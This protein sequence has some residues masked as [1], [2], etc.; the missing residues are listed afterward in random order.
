MSTKSVITK[1]EKAKSASYELGIT[2]TAKKN[3]ALKLLADNLKKYSA[4]IINENK[5]DLSISKNLGDAFLDRLELNNKRIEDLINQINK[6]V[7]LPDPIGEIIDKNIRSDG[8]KISRV[9]VALGVIGVIY[10]SRPN[11]TIDIASLCLKT[12]NSVILR[13]GKESFHTNLFLSKL[14]RSSLSSVGINKESVQFIEN[15]ER[16]TIN[17]LLKM[18]KH[19]DLMIPRGGEQLINLV[20]KESTM[21]SIVGGIGV[22]H[23]YIDKSAD[24]KQSIEIAINSKTQRPSVCNAL[25]TILVHKKIAPEFTPSIISALNT[26]NVE[27]KC[28]PS[29]FSLIDKNFKDNMNINEATEND[30]GTE[31]LSLKISIKTVES[32]Q[33]AI[34]HIKKY[35][36]GHT[37]AITA[38][39]EVARNIFLKEIDASAVMSNASTRFNDGGEFGLGAEIAISTNKFHARGP[40]GLDSLTSYKWI[41]EGSG[42]IRE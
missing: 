29:T 28:D 3:K 10:E 18:D 23:L 6:I 36:S 24:L 34:E 26:K 5:K 13:G 20:S 37:E 12:G 41:V 30:W 38:K 4:D 31:F 22:T 7:K 33:E 2:S 42:H 14:I 11:V 27:I 40:M 32:L 1:A 15:T 39:D 16:S 17:D 9:K 35:G 8:L 19:I 21:P 25:D